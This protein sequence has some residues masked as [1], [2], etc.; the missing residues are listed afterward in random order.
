MNK[1]LT[2]A[3]IVMFVVVLGVSAATPVFAAT[4]AGSSSAN[5]T[6]ASHDN[7]GTGVVNLGN[8]AGTPSREIC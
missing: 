6:P 1:I 8:S 5:C 7:S 4:Q 3:A 2:I